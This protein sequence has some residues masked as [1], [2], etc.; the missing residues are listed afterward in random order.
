MTVW[1][2]LRDLG[3]SALAEWRQA[4]RIGL[5][6]RSNPTPGGRD[7]ARQ[8]ITKINEWSDQSQTRTYTDADLQGL[9]ASASNLINAC[10]R[11]QARRTGQAEH[12]QEQAQTP[13]K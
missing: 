1:E 9:K 11:E 3:R 2:W 8:R 6:S 10:N 5:Q 7:V 13:T 4:A 12:E